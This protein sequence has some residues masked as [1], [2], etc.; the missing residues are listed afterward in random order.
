[1]R[2][3]VVQ[4]AVDAP[5]EFRG[6]RKG[7]DVAFD[8]GILAGKFREMRDEVRI[9]QEANVKNQIRIGRQTIAITETHQRN[10]QGP[11]GAALKF[12]R[13]K[14]PQ[15]VNI[16]ARGVD[17]NVGQLANRRHQFALAL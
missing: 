12:A 9:R 13:N 7:A 16:E 15:L 3:Q 1:M 4:Q 5:E 17:D 11:L 6:L 2:N 8:L 10:Q 14:L